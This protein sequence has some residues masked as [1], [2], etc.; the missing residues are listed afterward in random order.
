MKKRMG[1]IKKK[2]RKK[3][4]K[5]KKIEINI[6]KN[7]RKNIKKSKMKRAQIRK[8]ALQASNSAAI[9][10]E[11]LETTK[12]NLINILINLMRRRSIM[13]VIVEAVLKIIMKR[14]KK[15]T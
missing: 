14:E 10:K 3:I 8:L 12:L 6:E 13:I 5:E 7:T 4:E 9:L 1:K 15:K 11:K 2:K